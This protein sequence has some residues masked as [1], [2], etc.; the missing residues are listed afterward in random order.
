MAYTRTLAQLQTSLQ[1]RGQYENS[2]DITPAVELEVINDALVESYDVLVGR[3]LDYYTIAAP[4]FT[5]V[6]GTD[7]YAL[8]SDFYKLRKVEVLYCGLATDPTARWKT[9]HPIDLSGTNL[10]WTTSVPD[11]RY[12][13]RMQGGTTPLVFVPVPQNTDTI[14]VWYI[15]LPPQ[16]V[17]PTDTLQFQVP[18]EQKLILNIALRD[19]LIRQDLD[20]SGVLSEIDRLTIQLKQAGDNRDAA[21]PFYLSDRGRDYDDDDE[22]YW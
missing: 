10:I 12:R 17:N 7:S 13:Y 5:L 22:G 16:L 6:S 4:T 3:W 9:L 8:P 14:R 1:I 18:A 21:E 2:D 19:L 15:T 20:T 11:K